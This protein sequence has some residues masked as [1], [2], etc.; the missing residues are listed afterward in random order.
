MS[1][2]LDA[3]KRAESERGRGAVP[4]LHSQTHAATTP[5]TRNK[6]RPLGWLLAATA[7]VVLGLLVWWVLRGMATPA[8]PVPVAAPV[9]P[10]V[11]AQAPAPPPALPPAPPAPPARVSVL[12]PMAALPPSPPPPLA[13]PAPAQTVPA[14]PKP[15]A[16]K[17][18]AEPP[19]G[20]RVPSLQE[21][22]EA[23]R[24][25][26]PALVISGATYSENPLY[27]MVI[28]NGQVLHEG[29]TAAPGVVLEKIQQKEV[30]LRAQGQR[31]RMGY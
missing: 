12:P 28:V 3:L 27:R 22:P 4:G 26:L 25:Q 2:I 7:V 11:A 14:V 24:Q 18:V 21:L 10:E 31:Y 8:A 15:P 19:A 6:R 16:T 13:P 29:D 30:V 5:V 17:A 1:Y 23:T 9:R 20:P